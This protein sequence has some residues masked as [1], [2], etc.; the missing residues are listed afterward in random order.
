MNSLGQEVSTNSEF[1]T[2]ARCALNTRLATIAAIMKLIDSTST[3]CL[4]V[5]HLPVKAE[6]LRRPEL[7]G[8]PLMITAGTPG[9]QTV[10]DASVAAV[11]VRE[12]Q[13]VAEALSRCSGAV[14]LPSDSIYLS[15]VND[16]LLAA[17]CGVVPNVEPAGLGAF[18][19]DLTGMAGMYGGV[20]GL[21]GAILSACDQRLSPRLGI[22][23]GKFPARC[24]AARAYAGGWLR[25]PDDAA[26]WL[27]PLPVSWLPLERDDAARLA[28]FGIATLGDVAALTPASLTEFLG[29]TGLRAWNLAGGVDPEPVIPTVLPEVLSERLEFPFPVDTAAGVEAGLRALSERLWRSSALRTRRVGHVAIEGSL[30]AGGAWRFDR[31]LRQPAASTDALVRALLAGLDA[32]DALGAGRWPE[33]PLMDLTLTASDMSPESGRQ[34]ALWTQPPRRIMPNVAVAGVDRLTRMVPNSALPERRWAFAS[35]LAPLAA[36]SPV[37]VSCRGDTPQRVSGDPAGGKAVAK[38]VDLWEVDTEWWTPAPVRRRYWR[39][40]LDGGGL[41]TVYRDL[42]TGDWFRQGY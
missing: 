2:A 4:L 9:R 10:L 27:A 17:L 34:S 16:R 29:P 8:Q 37:W 32:Q 31:E 39:L 36:P 11:G 5:T 13:T 33:G 12:G 40:A 28:G 6:R 35:T 23:G 42:D 7:A 25:V 14:T 19:L 15:E 24:A 21:A 1:V 20:D 3:G 41:L 26:A 18:Y 22:G 38:V 30:L